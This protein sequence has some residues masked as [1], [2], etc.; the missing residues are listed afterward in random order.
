VLKPSAFEQEQ[1]AVK[2][3]K[4]VRGEYSVDELVVDRAGKRVSAGLGRVV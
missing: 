2:M 4:S 1:T 3:L